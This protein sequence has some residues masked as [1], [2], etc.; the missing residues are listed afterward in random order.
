MKKEST[1]R[2]LMLGGGTAAGIVIFLAIIAA[3]QYVV[4]QH[5]K[6]WDL[7]G[8]GKHT[9]APQSK[10][11]LE[12]FR[13]KNTPIEVLAFYEIK[14]AQARD[15]VK[16]L[17]EQ[18]RDVYPDF[19]YSFIDP[20]KDRAI[21][22]Q[23]KIDNYPTLVLK[24][25]DK[26]ERISTATEETVTNALVKL[27]RSEIKKVYF[28]KGHGEL[29]PASN[30]ADGFAS[31]KDQ[32]EKQNY[33]TEELVLLQSPQV[34]QD[35]TILV[36][37]GPKIDLMDP[38]LESLKAYLR[39]GGNLF[40]LLNPFKCPKLATFLKDYGF[41]TTDDIIVD[42]KSL[43][44]FLM[45]VVTT[46]IKSPITK[47]FT[48]ASVFPECRSVKAATNPGENIVVNNLALTEASVSW[49]INEEQLKRGDANFDEKT[50]V[51]G[52]I[53]VMAVSTVTAPDQ[54]AK[55]S[56]PGTNEAKQ[57]PGNEKTAK[58]ESTN[59][60]AGD[61]KPKKARVVVVGSSLFASNKY[62]GV[63]GN[64]DVFLNTISWL[65]EDENL[66]AIR[67]KSAKAQPLILT[68]NEPLVILLV[69]VVIVPLAW[70]LAGF[71]VF[72]YRRRTVN[73]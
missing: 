3:V 66:I 1:L 53:S 25:G 54:A 60:A 20:D 26:T 41:E 46:Y 13:T 55:T 42:V 21:A 29:S 7:T 30:E 64:R 11:L 18:Y 39:R 48:L 58:S 31:A 59:D 67:P 52:P 50:D 40:V 71:F 63:L 12:E 72:L 57:N 69:P 65:A 5:P 51:K 49:T 37:A 62:F 56:K 45:P 10:K 33:K 34:P 73:G 9:L 32:V 70:I 15:S 17:L 35:A 8:G 47:D 61:G 27:M 4:L 14:D 22:V 28:L 16:D 23:N 24:A 36:I 38:E 68:S 2:N 6:R 44:N 19:K 43:S